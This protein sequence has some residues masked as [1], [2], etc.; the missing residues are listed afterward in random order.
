MWLPDAVAKN[1][2]LTL[3][4]IIKSLYTNKTTNTYIHT[5]IHN[6]MQIPYRMI[7]YV[8]QT[9]RAVWQ[10]LRCPYYSL[11]ADYEGTLPN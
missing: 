11:T 4:V 5:I 6:I 1:S 10:L 9:K 3:Y 7:T 2:Q 8:C